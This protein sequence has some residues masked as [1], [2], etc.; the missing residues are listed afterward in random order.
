[1]SRPK[2]VNLDDE[3]SKS[4]LRADGRAEDSCRLISNLSFCDRVGYAVPGNPRFS[5]YDLGQ[6][7]DDYARSL[8]T[9]F[10]YSMEQIPCD[11]PS[12]AKYS[13]AVDCG[14]CTRAYKDWLCAVIMPRCADFSSKAPS[15]QVRNNA[16]NFINGT[17]VSSIDGD[18]NF[19]AVNRHV[20]AM[21]QSRNPWIDSTIQP[22]PYKELLPCGSL[23]YR[24]VQSCPS[25]LGFACPQV[26]KWYNQS[27]GTAPYCNIPGSI[28]GVSIAPLSTPSLP[29]TISSIALVLL[30]Q[31]LF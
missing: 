5:R 10:S 28:W 20:A 6:R 9:N 17:D 30:W 11:A 29:I 18:P 14:N 7:Y 21:N 22:G 25:V 15:L 23:C 4:T 26:G 16:Q 27:Y 1:M 8:Y 19:S 3:S 13:L 12:D 24:L 31:S 2:Q